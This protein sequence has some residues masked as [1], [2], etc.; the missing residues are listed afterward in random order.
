MKELN[1][2][3]YTSVYHEILSL[4]IMKELNIQRYTPVYCE[5]LSLFIF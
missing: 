2:Q 3:R 1:I 4:Y 5:S